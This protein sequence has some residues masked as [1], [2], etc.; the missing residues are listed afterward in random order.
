MPSAGLP[1][2]GPWPRSSPLLGLLCSV[3]LSTPLRMHCRTQSTLL[4]AVP[5][6]MPDL[7]FTKKQYLAR[8]HFSR[9][10]WSWED[11]K[12]YSFDAQCTQPACVCGCGSGGGGQTLL[13]VRRRLVAL[14]MK[15][16]PFT[17]LFSGSVNECLDDFIG[18]SSW[19]RRR[20]GHLSSPEDGRQGQTGPNNIPRA[21]NVT[22]CLFSSYSSTP[23][24]SLQGCQ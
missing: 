17:M 10:P 8:P 6:R 15:R 23:R 5:H 2:E 16:V 11:W 14:E 7:L 18:N 3:F 9:S 12:Q 1:W 4:P 24:F 13:P 21:Q 20:K 19:T 22:C